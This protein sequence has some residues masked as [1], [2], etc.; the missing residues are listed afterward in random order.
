MEYRMESLLVDWKDRL[1]VGQKVGMK[2]H[3]KV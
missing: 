2:V 3:K 1:M